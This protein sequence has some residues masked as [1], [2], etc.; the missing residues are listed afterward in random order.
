MGY[1]FTDKDIV[2]TRSRCFQINTAWKYGFIVLI[3]IKYKVHSCSF[4][5]VFYVFRKSKRTDFRSSLLREVFRRTRKFSLRILIL[6]GSIML[7]KTCL[8]IQCKTALINNIVYN[9]ITLRIDIAEL[10]LCY[11]LFILDKN[12]CILLL[13]LVFF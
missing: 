13:T 5:S 11:C 4:F 2:A 10:A 8:I 3:L 7:L 9:S 6:N 12:Y 1:Y